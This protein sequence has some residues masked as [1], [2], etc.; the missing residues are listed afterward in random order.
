MTKT[1]VT[2][3]GKIFEIQII[4]KGLTECIYCTPIYIYIHMYKHTHIY[5][6]THISFKS[7]CKKT[8]HRKTSKTFEKALHKKGY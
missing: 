2:E 6:K 7:I 8:A 3:S 4:Q 5:T 1:Q